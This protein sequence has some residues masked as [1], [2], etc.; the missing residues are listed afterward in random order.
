MKASKFIQNINSKDQKNI[1]QK[2][3]IF[4]FIFTG[5]ILKLTVVIETVKYFLI[6]FFVRSSKQNLI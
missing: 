1:K 2:N 4:H 5:F 6:E 3:K